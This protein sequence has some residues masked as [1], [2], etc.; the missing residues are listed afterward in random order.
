MTRAGARWDKRV[1]TFCSRKISSQVEVVVL[2]ILVTTFDIITFARRFEIQLKRRT[3][4][5]NPT[6]L[7]KEDRL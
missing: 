7:R 4:S 1:K 5:T 2:T 6:V 3:I